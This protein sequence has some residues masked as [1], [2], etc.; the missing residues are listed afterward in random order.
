MKLTQILILIVAVWSGFH[1]AMGQ[2]WTQS[3][4]PTNYW[5]SITGSADGSKLFAFGQSAKTPLQPQP[6]YFSTDGGGTWILTGAP[7]NYWSSI[8]SSA[9][10]MKIVAGISGGGVGQSGLYISSDGGSSWVSNSTIPLQ[11]WTSVASSADGSHLYAANN[12]LYVSTN[13]GSSWYS[14]IAGA[15]DVAISSDGTKVIIAKGVNNAVCYSTDSG[16][17]W[18]T[19]LYVNPPFSV[20]SSATGDVLGIISGAG[21]PAGTILVSTNAG[22][23]WITNNT[24]GY[25]GFGIAISADGSDIIVAG[26]VS[27]GVLYGPLYTSTNSGLTWISNSIPR[28]TWY[29]VYCSADG[30]KL[31]AVSSGTNLTS[32]GFGHIWISQ[33][34]PSPQL[35]L[36]PSP[37]NIAISWLIP[38]TNFVLQQS[39]DLISWSN[40]M[41]T[42][43]PNFTNLNNQ[44]TIWPTNSSSFFRLSTP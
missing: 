36:T 33:T 8:A 16:L 42:P 4:A 11:K 30:N 43:T 10:G 38:S 24:I 41:D 1:S 3:S 44:L 22:N 31:V 15:S 27:S 5:V 13:F 37:T 19:N 28:S 26:L 32:T 29:G 14:S 40:I 18:I 9:D 21:G 20:A 6:I 39:G 34:T 25:A 2:T 12:G 35:N 17:N 23:S 7:T